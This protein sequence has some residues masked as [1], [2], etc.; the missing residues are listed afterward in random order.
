M[1][2]IIMALFLLGSFSV[3]ADTLGDLVGVY[4]AKDKDGEAVVTR[5]LVRG[6]TLFDPALYHYE[7]SILRNKHE[8]ERTV[9]LQSQ[10]GKTL[11]GNDSDDCD[12]PDCHAFDTFEV[13]IEKA[14]RGAKLTL[15]YE[16]YNTEDGSN[17]V[18][19]FSG[20]AVF[21]K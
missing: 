1:K 16:G 18:E 2:A 12:D 3:L 21:V 7:V 11:L 13:K 8:I 19:H 6:P 15:E 9:F 4:R 10:D 20:S 17:E 14:G 5:T